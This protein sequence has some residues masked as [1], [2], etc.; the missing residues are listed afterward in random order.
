[1]PLFFN[2][3][4]QIFIFTF[5]NHDWHNIVLS[6]LVRPFFSLCILVCNVKFVSYPL[7]LFL[8]MLIFKLKK[9][10]MHCIAC[11]IPVPQPG[12]ESMVPALEILSLNN[13]TSREVSFMFI[14][15]QETEFTY[16]QVKKTVRQP[17]REGVSQA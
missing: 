9:K 8:V 2:K 4:T 15:A 1:M 3:T 10:M 5:Q 17:E 12:I 13:C 14:S 6:I 7:Y 16:Q 11:R